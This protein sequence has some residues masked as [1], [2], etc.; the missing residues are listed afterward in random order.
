V[1]LPVGHREAA[2]ASEAYRRLEGTFRAAAA[3]YLV[4]SGVGAAQA[5]QIA[6]RRGL[7]VWASVLPAGGG[8]GA[9]HAHH[10]HDLA[11]V[12]G[13]FYLGRVGPPLRFSD[14]RGE[15]SAVDV[16]H[17]VARSAV[18]RPPF[19]AEMVVEPALG[20]LVLFPPWIG[21]RVEGA[22]AAD[23]GAEALSAREQCDGG[24]R[25]CTDAGFRV[26]FSFNLHGEWG[27]T[28]QTHA[29]GATG[30]GLLASVAHWPPTPNTTRSNDN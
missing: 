1:A 23:Q 21:H 11:A 27:E 8:P 5:E 4:N 17:S 6:G 30:A 28:A 13:V 12:S 19:T 20:R 7:L 3:A 10:R 25:S 15:R 2:V 14:P 16:G 24:N 29:A 22:Q 26:A 18:P 9:S